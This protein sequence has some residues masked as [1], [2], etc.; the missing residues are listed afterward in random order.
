M[1]ANKN[2]KRTDSNPKPIGGI[3]LLFI[4]FL[5]IGMLVW[6]S[7]ETR[8][9]ELNSILAVQSFRG[10]VLKSTGEFRS[11]NWI[12]TSTQPETLFERL[13]EIDRSVNKRAAILARKG[14]G[15][16]TAHNSIRGL[17]G[18][19][20]D[21]QESMDAAHS[22]ITTLNASSLS[23][24]R[25]QAAEENLE[26][27]VKRL[28]NLEFVGGLSAAKKSEL[29]KRARLVNNSHILS[30]R[31]FKEITES[32]SKVLTEVS[33][34]YRSGKTRLS[35][36]ERELLGEM[37]KQSKEVVAARKSLVGA[38]GGTTLGDQL[39]EVNR[40]VDDFDTQATRVDSAISAVPKKRLIKDA[41]IYVVCA[42]VLCLTAYIL[43]SASLASEGASA[44]SDIES[45]I[46]KEEA[47][48]TKEAQQSIIE[49]IA[50]LAQKDLTVT[51][52]ETEPRTREIALASQMTVKNF[53]LAI[54]QAINLSSNV[55]SSAEQSTRTVEQAGRYSEESNRALEETR[56]NSVALL[57]LVDAIK[58]TGKEARERIDLAVAAVKEGVTIAEKTVETTGKTNQMVLESFQNTKEALEMMQHIPHL[59]EEMKQNHSNVQTLAVNIKLFAN[60]LGN[61]SDKEACEA[62]AAEME[63]VAKTQQ[64]LSITLVDNVNRVIDKAR[65]A[66]NDIESGR[67]HVASMYS[68]AEESGEALV[69]INNTTK[70]LVVLLSSLLDD[71]A[72]IERRATSVGKMMDD[73]IG[74]NN[75]MKQG[76]E[77][78]TAAVD[79]VAKYARTLVLEFESWVLPAR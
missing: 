53:V 8:D 77:E 56:K 17:V 73:V 19:W 51:F 38:V 42:V 65:A 26:D 33:A 1:P 25:V 11:T 32:F 63:Q 67:K 68:D 6:K 18:S 54:N 44:K 22:H 23:V 40:L 12:I 72:G 71:N 58:N 16:D 9:A 2:T 39:E 49:G 61:D 45:R 43:F 75:Q 20:H 31:E 7:S 59:V 35:K 4:A 55:I 37:V 28:S 62:M 46:V 21:L 69:Q 66:Q 52:D 36:G 48:R 14:D 15:L 47:S 13:G 74:L 50:K 79:G 64:D 3:V 29:L 78:N 70:D 30:T 57:D 60:R 27:L 41:Y 34:S 10:E 76:I 5:T 24:N